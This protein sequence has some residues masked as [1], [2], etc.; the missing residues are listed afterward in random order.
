MRL[1]LDSYNHRQIF[2]FFFPLIL[3]LFLFLL[4]P[5]PCR[6]ASARVDVLRVEGPIV[7]IVAEYLDRGIGEAEKGAS[8]C[9]I[10]LSTPGGLYDTTQQIVTRIMNARVPIVVYVSPAGG[11]AGSAGT[12][13]TISAHVAAMAPGSRIGAAHP[14][15]IG[16][17]GAEMP[18]TQAQKITEDAAAWVR[19]IAEMRGR[20]AEAAQMAVRESKSY[21]DREALEAKLIDLRAEHMEDLLN[22]LEGREVKLIN[23]QKIIL[24]VKGAALNRREMSTIERILLTV[25]NPNIAYI[26]MTVGM[27]GIIVEL[28]NPGAMFPGIAGVISLLLALY[29]LGTLN[30]HWGGILLIILAFALF[31]AEAFVVSHGLLT[32]GGI[33]SLVMGSLMLFSRGSPFPEI[34][35]SLIV[36]MS[37]GI[38]AFF[39]FLLGA[40]I[41]GQKRQAVTGMEGL[42]GET[43]VA[44]TPLNPSGTVLIEGERW[45]AVAEENV[46][47]GEKVTV[48]GVE[49]LRLKVK[50]KK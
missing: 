44:L 4:I 31:V 40:V 26:L 34:S 39:I 33:V 24:Q 30:A 2:I 20:N 11:W 43:G 17:G 10:E 19:S 49:G 18:A 35:I 41:R 9:I 12:F 22:Q 13:I 48:A 45:H 8:C 15:A 37:M 3:G 42:L 14:V 50:R 16:T 32:A 28:Y 36:G 1:N 47:A 21:S 6:A 27:L 25:S 7:P 38:S 5:I 29:A 23:G 46:E